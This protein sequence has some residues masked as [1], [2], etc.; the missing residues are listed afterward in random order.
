MSTV[1]VHCR[2]CGEELDPARA[3]LKYKTCMVCGEAEARQV[4]HLVA[5][6][7]KSNYMLFT[8]PADL[9]GINQKGGLVK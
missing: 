4:K 2:E 6:M 1:F 8:N 7:H 5:P 3:T 9:V